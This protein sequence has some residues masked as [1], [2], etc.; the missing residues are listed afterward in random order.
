MIPQ[1]I[2]HVKP[3]SEFWMKNSDDFNQ[4]ST[5]CLTYYQKTLKLSRKKIAFEE[6]AYVN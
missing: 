4:K 2:K 3:K 6:K 1:L 5:I